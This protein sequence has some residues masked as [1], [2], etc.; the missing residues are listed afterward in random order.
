VQYIDIED[1][2]K[3][4]SCQYRAG[5]RWLVYD[6]LRG[7]KWLKRVC[8]FSGYGGAAAWCKARSGREGVFRIR[9]LA[10]VLAAIN[11]MRLPQPTVAER[12]LLSELLGRRPVTAYKEAIPVELGLLRQRYFPVVWNRWL[13]PLRAVSTFQLLCRS[14]IGGG[15]T[16]IRVRDS[17]GD[18]SVAVTAFAANVRQESATGGEWLLAGAIEGKIGVTDGEELLESGMLV[19]YRSKLGIQGC[20]GMSIEQVHDPVDQILV[21]TPYFAS[22]D[23]QHG[24][25]RFY[26]G[27]L[28]VVRPGERREV[29]DFSFFDF[30]CA[31]IFSECV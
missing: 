27:M 19:F 3:K 31:D 18:F 21:R 1:M 13:D 6:I 23:R 30:D 24:L 5:G 4:L 2:K 28:K 7:A 11:G 14:E 8:C 29:M 26:D 10:E 12:Q 22:Y 15:K 9:V 17:F 20:S 25:I 16:N